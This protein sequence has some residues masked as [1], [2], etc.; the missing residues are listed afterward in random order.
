MEFLLEEGETVHYRLKKAVEKLAMKLKKQRR[1]TVR[2]LFKWAGAL[3]II[4]LIP[5]IV[6]PNF[7]QDIV[8][9]ILSESF[10][11]FDDLN[12]FYQIYLI[13]SYI[14]YVI[15]FFGG[16]V[17]LAY[18]LVSNYQVFLPL[19]MNMALEGEKTLVVTNKKLILFTEKRKEIELELYYIEEMVDQDNMYPVYSKIE[20]NE[21][22]KN[23]HIADFSF[24]NLGDEVDLNA[25]QE[26]LE[27]H[28]QK[29]YPAVT[30]NSKRWWEQKQ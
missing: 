25:V 12:L 3:V 4:F 17:T 24:H 8:P 11:V 1:D 26:L 19:N 16:V 22:G 29:L 13:F 5:L 9:V 28:L 20:E 2:W 18:Y 7:Y 30:F 15:I 10:H 6:F 23:L 21:L 27:K 14:C